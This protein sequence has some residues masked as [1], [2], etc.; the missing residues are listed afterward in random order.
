MI[1]DKE[2]EINM[3]NVETLETSPSHDLAAPSEVKQELETELTERTTA[4]AWFSILV[5]FPEIL[6]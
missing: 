5:S 1:E 4:K 3:G 2:H 6:E